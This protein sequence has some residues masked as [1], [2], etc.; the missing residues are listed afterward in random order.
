MTDRRYSLKE[1][2][3]AYRNANQWDVGVSLS[4]GILVNTLA[5][6]PEP[7]REP[8][9]SKFDEAAAKFAAAQMIL[10]PGTPELENVSARA[11]ADLF[12][13]GARWQFEH[14]ALN[15]MAE[16]DSAKASKDEG[17]DD[18]V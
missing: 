2:E 3:A 18:A 10:S 14:L 11:L 15:K 16:S 6:L 13:Q 5:A 1:I 4:W 9:E 7:E 17:P 8:S 12:T